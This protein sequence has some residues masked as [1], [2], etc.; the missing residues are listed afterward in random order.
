MRPLRLELE[1][2]TAFRERTCVDFG[3]AELFALAGP[4]G[5]GKSSVIDAVVFAL[6][7]E[8]P[9]LGGRAVAPVISTGKEQARV[10]LDFEV[11]DDAYTA[12]RVVR[13]TS[14]GATTREARLER[15][16]H[17]MAG[18]ARGLTTAVEELLGLDVAQFT[19]SVVLPQGDF[20]RFLQDKPADRQDLLVKLLD[21]GVY[22]RVRE[23]ARSRKAG[24]D[25]EVTALTVALE[26]LAEAS[27]EAI[28]AAGA[29]V[30][31]LQALVGRVAAARP[32]LEALA[33][34]ERLAREA[35]AAASE[36]AT[37]LA[38]V[39]VPTDMGRLH[40]EAAAAEAARRARHADVAAAEEAETTTSAARAVLPDAGQLAAWRSGRQELVT[41]RNREQRGVPLTAA[42]ERAAE[43]ARGKFAGTV[44]ALEEARA[45]LTRSERAHAAAHVAAELA[46]G[47]PC[48]V[49]DHRVSALPER[50]SP[51]DLAAAQE[52]C[53]AAQRTYQSADTAAR[54]ADTAT[55]RASQTLA[56]VREQITGRSHT[57]D[58]APDESAL[59][60]LLTE[61]D[62]ADAEVRA[63]VTHLRAARQA[64]RVSED[65][66]LRARDA[67]DG[68]W[69]RFDAARDA[70]GDLAPPPVTRDDLA[71]AWSTLA[72]FA[73]ERAAAER[74]ASREA[75][76]RGRAA[77]ERLTLQRA[78]LDAAAAD[79]DLP[80]AGESRLAGALATAHAH[81]QRLADERERAAALRVRITAH[82]EAAQVAGT[83][84]G[85][86][87]ARGFEAWL[88]D[89]AL[90]R[91]VAGGSAILHELSR[92]Q[93]AFALDEQRRFAVV[94]HAAAD[95]QRQAATLSGGET[96]LAS[97]A[98]ALTLADELSG[99]AVGATPRLGS[100][101]LDEGF[102]T[103]DPESLDT[104]AIALEDLG[105]RGRT[106]GVVTHVRDLADRMPTRFEVRKGPHTA[107]VERVDA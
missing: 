101:F 38:A 32:V 68:A 82:R 25:G 2:F 91:L 30:T 98:L 69:Q 35:S 9:R 88:L 64:G 96:F 84:A 33:S 50:T 74:T 104:V 14:A 44:E 49:C 57:L 53:E 62:R 28:A 45:R 78:V 52:A 24:A 80:D 81:Q 19:K 102:G 3:D 87:S 89:E 37:R 76:A 85:H 26:G 65:A 12:V 63:A 61:A 90:A 66:A 20:A 47:E 5:S 106:V 4:T 36:R 72:F 6:Y 60:A 51:P 46:I 77:A 79:L 1:G 41:L 94:D 93:Y 103:L 40:A 107:T 48:P 59:A 55:A 71:A 83:L 73:S 105:A 13:R 97:L 11:A 22:E 43:N 7:G 75:D 92:G 86:L 42:A 58:G 17:I 70:L 31:A 54:E 23:R 8:T 21:L 100:M 27:D 10:R 67:R 39:T 29:R 99:M 16:E 95:V 18:D 56:D 15:G 34:Q